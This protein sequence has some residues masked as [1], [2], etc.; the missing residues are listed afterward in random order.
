MSD[1][2]AAQVLAEAYT[3]Y[4]KHHDGMGLDFKIAINQVREKSEQRGAV[5]ELENASKAMKKFAVTQSSDKQG[6]YIH[7]AN[8]LLDRALHRA[9][10][11]GDE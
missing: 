8:M 1:F 10:L 3:L 4:K 6:T 2:N 9:N 5:K 7:A 11:E